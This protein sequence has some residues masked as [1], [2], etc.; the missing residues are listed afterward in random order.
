MS[1]LVLPFWSTI[2]WCW[3]GSENGTALEGRKCDDWKLEM[4]NSKER[5]AAVSFYGGIW[6]GETVFNL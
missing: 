2:R 1:G 3:I 5:I 4:E 6:F